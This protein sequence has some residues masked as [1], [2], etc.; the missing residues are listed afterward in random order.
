VTARVA[1]EL[2]TPISEALD[3]VAAA[4]FDGAAGRARLAPLL[5]RFDAELGMLAADD[6][7]FEL[8]QVTRMDWAL[9]DVPAEPD[10]RPGD[11]WAWRVIHG[12]VPGARCES[13]PLRNAA[14]RSVTGLF[15]VFPGE[16]TWVRDRI[17]GL[18]LRLFDG[19][20]P[21]LD[22]DP[23]R[24]AALWELRLVPDPS[25]GC[26]V[27]RPPIDYPLELLDALEREHARRFASPRWPTMQELRR[28]RLR[29]LRAGKRTPIE[30][31]LRWR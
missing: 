16:P 19:V 14:A 22:A 26:F 12:R 5:A 10:A 23:E 21:F 29:Y 2:E 31:M 20:G 15:E 9:C 3:A 18:V 25:G 24:P 1:G 27:A 13:T 6:P 30:R 28:A 11:T 17:S 4:A 8:L 7:D